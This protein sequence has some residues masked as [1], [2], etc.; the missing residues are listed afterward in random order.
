MTHAQP[1][2]IL[3]IDDDPACRELIVAMVA[4]QPDLE[5]VATAP[6]GM[7][8][9]EQAAAL[10]PTLILLDLNMPVMDGFEALPLLKTLAPDAVVV[11][12]SSLDDSDAFEMARTL[13]ASACITKFMSA[14]ELLATLRSVV[15]CHRAAVLR[16][17]T[18]W[19]RACATSSPLR[20][21][22]KMRPHVNARAIPS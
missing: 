8:G 21:R 2:T 5:V 12:R 9:A 19:N 7:L 3:V 14:E 11:V 16:A 10:A 22:P 4:D 6:N 17:G 1:T 20:A 13:G 18:R 15:P